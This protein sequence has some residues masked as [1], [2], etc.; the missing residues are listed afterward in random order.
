MDS[1]AKLDALTRRRSFYLLITVV[2]A[3]LPP[4]AA[5]GLGYLWK[6]PAFID[7]VSS[8]LFGLKSV[9]APYMPALHILLALILLALILLRRRFGRAFALLV[10]LN[11]AVTAVVQTGVRTEAYGLVILTELFLWYLIVIALWVWEAGV[12]RTDYSFKGGTLRPYWLIPLAIIAFWDPDQAWNLSL[13]FFVYG[14]APTAFCM[15]TPIYLTVL[16]FAYPRVNLPLL[17]VHSFL[18]MVVGFISFAIS[19]MQEPSAGVYWA[20]LH[21][22]LLVISWYAFRLGMRPHPETQAGQAP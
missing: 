19:F 20:L 10:A 4:F 21:M 16:V 22:P 8:D 7:V 1:Y 2:P 15:I 6:M 17:R 12:L 13:S 5:A 18:G 3:V 11:L 14:F 9:Y